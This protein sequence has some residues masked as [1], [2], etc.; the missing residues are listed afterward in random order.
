F[1]EDLMK[2]LNTVTYGKKEVMEALQAGRVSTLLITEDLADQMD[3]IYDDVTEFGSE[4]LVF[5]NQTES[6]A[7]LKGFGG[8]AARLRW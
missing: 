1:M 2:G 5:S 4:L 7:Q 3:S 6:G 8:L